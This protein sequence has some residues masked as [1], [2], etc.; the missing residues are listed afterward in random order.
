MIA[1]LKNAQFITIDGAKPGAKVDKT[2]IVLD[3]GQV[4]FLICSQP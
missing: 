3:R 4:K 1:K 2:A